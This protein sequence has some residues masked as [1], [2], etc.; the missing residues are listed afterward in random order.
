MGATM[1]AIPE[2]IADW[3]RK[4][5]EA[6]LARK[7]ATAPA[8]VPT[9]SPFEQR[10]MAMVSRGIPVTVL[11]VKDKP[12]IL[13]EWQKTATTDIA[14]IKKWAAQYPENN[15]GAVARGEAGAVFFLEID[16]NDV[17]RRIKAETGKAMPDTF[18]VRSSPKRGH[19]YFRHTAK[20]IAC[21]NLSQ[22]Y[23]KRGDWSLRA[24][25]QYVVGPGSI[26]PKTG[27]PYTIIDDLPIID[28]PDWLVEWCESQRENKLKPAEREAGELVPHGKI[29]D[30]LTRFIGKMI[31]EN[32]PL[33]ATL[34]ATLAAV[35]A[36]CAPPIDESRVT[37]DVQGMYSRYPAGTPLKDQKPDVYF[38]GK[39]AGSTST[40]Q[41]S[42][43]QEQAVTSRLTLVQA[44]TMKSKHVRWFWPGKILANKPN[45]LF[46][47]PGLG[48]GFVGTDFIARMTT[49]REFYDGANN[50]KPCSAIVCCSED[51]WDETILPRLLV[52]G[53]NVERVFFMKEEH[54][55]ADSVEEGLM[56]LD[57][58]LPKIAELLVA[59][60]DKNIRIILI[61]PLATYMGELDPNKDKEVR[62]VYTAMDRFAERYNVC[63]ILIAHPNK[64]EVASAI[65]RLSGA[66]ALTSV[67]RN[68]W[69]VEKDQE[70]KGERYMI[71]VKGNLAGEGHKVGLKFRVDDVDDTGIVGE[72]G[73]TIRHIGKLSW[74]GTTEKDADT[75]LADVAGGGRET[76]R[77]IRDQA[78]R[79]FLSE[80]VATEVKPAFE[81]Y[82][83]IAEIG[84]NEYEIRKA[85]S[86]LKVK[87]QRIQGTTYWGSRIAHFDDKR[88]ELMEKSAV[89]LGGKD[90]DV[91]LETQQ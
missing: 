25:G 20:S 68:T 15:V 74:V 18:S 60:A 58:D 71:S 84:I 26:S 4:D 78:A 17:L 16:S 44:S 83:K 21:G 23:V 2:G 53:A 33:D 9:V 76:K 72:D 69:L 80:Y 88:K 19:F 45:V 85:K 32:V 64:N 36:N 14:Q 35:H 70:N 38:G 11:R 57:S 27:E 48:K 8:P 46:G 89:I 37:R 1:A 40:V 43:S 28:I 63:F 13:A 42:S 52:A 22:G 55:V 5:V 24:D 30:Y 90:A 41:P 66:K 56:A 79:D 91:K 47:E 86:S 62:P 82:E 50:N 77:K 61:D 49:G 39:P 75:V 10:A 29:N 67:F 34:V 6:M 65:N 87:H 3:A 73:E 59:H 7:T 31:H 12:A 54:G 81:I 51:S